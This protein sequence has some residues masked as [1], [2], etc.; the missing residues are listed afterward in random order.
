M[1]IVVATCVA[2]VKETLTWCLRVILTLNDD[3]MINDMTGSD[4]QTDS[5]I[6]N[7]I[8]QILV[9]YMQISTLS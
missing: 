8:L 9:Y 7:S 1:K 3:D 2:S 5:N 6:L 4:Q